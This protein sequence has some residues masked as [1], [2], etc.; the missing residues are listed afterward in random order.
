MQRYC[1]A[2]YH[3]Q[4]EGSAK[5]V[6][7]GGKQCKAWG[8]RC[9]ACGITGHYSHPSGTQ[10]VCSLQIRDVKL[11]VPNH[12]A[13][14]LFIRVTSSNVP[15]VGRVKL[16]FTPDTGAE[17]NVIGLRQL[18]LSLSKSD[19]SACQDEVLAANRSRLSPVGSFKATLTLGDASVDTVISVFRG[20]DDS[21]LS[22]YDFRH[23]RL[24]PDDYPK[25]ISA[26][27]SKETTRLHSNTGDNRRKVEC[28]LRRVL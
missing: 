20:V 10:T 16:C 18:R 19:L 23:L 3:G 1:C 6:G 27:R 7:C 24:I 2:S 12:H 4:N 26:L 22:W 8:K 15:V 25:Q 11:T 17:A 21:L 28:P 9:D 14:K 5:C 13:S